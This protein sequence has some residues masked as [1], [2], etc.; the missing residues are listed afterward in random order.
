[1]KNLRTLIASFLILTVS[2][3][4]AQ[5]IFTKN[6]NISFFSKSPIENISATN[7]QV[8][9]IF[10]P[11]NGELAFSVIV[12][13]FHFEKSL[14]EEHFNENYLESSKYPK[15]TFKGAV[16]DMSKINFKAD[17]TY[18]VL[19]SGD[20]T[21]HGKTNKVNTP[22]TIVVKNGIPSANAT[23][24]VKLAD[25]DVSIPKLVKDNIAEKIEI[26]VNCT[27]DQKL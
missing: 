2:A 9:S 25:Y 13:S 8:M 24:S 11:Q 15:S 14:M 6:G 4:N 27:Y 5:K 19:V 26:T 21:I 22:G 23:F 20:L 10:N 1:M 18:P 7:N 12:K 17:G 3:A 16:T